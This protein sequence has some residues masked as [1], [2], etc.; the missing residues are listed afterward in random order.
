[1]IWGRIEKQGNFHK[2]KKV[3]DISTTRILLLSQGNHR[4]YTGDAL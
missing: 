3:G 4:K 1:L 2:G